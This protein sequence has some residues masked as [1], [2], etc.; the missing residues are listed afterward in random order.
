MYKVKITLAILA[1]IVFSVLM[2]TLPDKGDQILAFVWGLCS[3]LTIGVLY[4]DHRLTKKF[5]RIKE[6]FE[7]D[8]KI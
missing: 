3:F 4:T 1:T 6:L 8:E 5:N 7:K 2:F